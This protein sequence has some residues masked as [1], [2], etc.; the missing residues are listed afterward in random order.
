[1]PEPAATLLAAL[2]EEERPRAAALCELLQQGGCRLAVKEAKS[3]PVLSAQRPDD[4]R[5][6][7]AF[8]C[9]KSGAKLRLYLREA[10]ADPALLAALA[11]PMK[12]AV[13]R[14]GP[15]KRLA[16]SAACNPR[17]PMGFAFDLDGQQLQ[18]CRHTAFFFPL[19]AENIPALTALLRRELALD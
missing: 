1:M 6:L 10:L 5:T 7:A 11:D 18:R 16:N 12:A 19:R 4:G 3:G 14:A 15:C 13:H 9:R 17:C 2:E 8:V